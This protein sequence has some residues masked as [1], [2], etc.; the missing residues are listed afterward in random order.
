MRVI[1]YRKLHPH[2]KFCRHKDNLYLNRC[3]AKEKHIFFNMAKKC[4]M[5]FPKT[6]VLDALRG[7]KNDK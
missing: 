7:D 5:Y 6:S 4:P 2:C 3:G 1:E